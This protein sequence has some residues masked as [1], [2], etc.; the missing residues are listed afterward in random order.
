[1]SHL[2]KR[3]SDHLPLLVNI[4]GGQAVAVQRAKHKRFRFEA[5]WLREEESSEVVTNVWQ[6]GDDVG[7][8]ISCTT[9]KL[10][11]WS[12]KKFGNVAK[13]IRQ[14]QHQMKEL[15]EKE[16]TEEIVNQM[17]NVDARI[18]ELERREEMYWHQ[19]SRQNWIESSDQ[20]TR[21]FHQ[22][23][24]QRE[25]CN[26]VCCIKNEAGEWFEEE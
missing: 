8:N 13:E 16:P 25:Q 21:F 12:R 23:A 15:M 5:M 11:A 9:N 3:K 6:K 2:T 20:N 19:R 7:V 18:D 10:T 22:K 14:C 1:M 26:N 4:R 17:R 24:S